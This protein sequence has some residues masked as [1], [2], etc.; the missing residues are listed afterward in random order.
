MST[1][2]TIMATP[3]CRPRQWA[4]RFP[5][6]ATCKSQQKRSASLHG[7]IHCGTF[8]RDS[9]DRTRHIRN[10]PNRRGAPQPLPLRPFSSRPS[11]SIRAAVLRPLFEN[12]VSRGTRLLRCATHKW[13]WR[14]KS[15]RGLGRLA[16]IAIEG[17]PDIAPKSAGDSPRTGS[18]PRM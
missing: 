18:Q 7:R 6:K 13:V 12:N 2:S 17:S 4:S 14:C 3:P 15:G 11:R 8:K 10:G 9:R 5:S 1:R 16:Q